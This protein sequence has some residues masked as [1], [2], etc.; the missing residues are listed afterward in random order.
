MLTLYTSIG[1]LTTQKTQNGTVIPV[2]QTGGHDY[3]LAPREL[4]LWSS[5][6]F[7]IL[8]KEEAQVSYINQL[9]PSQLSD[10]PDFAYILRRLLMRGIVIQGGGVTGVEALYRLLAQMHIVPVKDS[11]FTRCIACFR[12]WRH[13]HIPLSMFP[14]YPKKPSCTPMETLILKLSE[15]LSFSVAELLGHMEYSTNVPTQN[16]LDSVTAVMKIDDLAEQVTLH[17]VQLPVLQGIANLY[18][19]KQILLER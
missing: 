3:A 19:K 10:E 12:A 16:D 18:L 15:E 14:H 17:H 6:A 5:L 2:V 1:H 11:L 8:T 13:G 4:L 9:V 7:Q